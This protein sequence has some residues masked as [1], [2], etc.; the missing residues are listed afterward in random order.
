MHKLQVIMDNGILQ[1]TLSKPGGIVTGIQYNG[2]NNLLEVQNTETNRGYWDL[3][4]SE[5]GS[6]GTTGTFD[7]GWV[8][9]FGYL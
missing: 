3:V 1:V 6:V 8:W 2:I 9:E 4:W 5:A 7:V